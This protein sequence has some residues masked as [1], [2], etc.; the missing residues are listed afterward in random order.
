VS[1]PT[2]GA[3]AYDGYYFG[4]FTTKNRVEL[5]KAAG[6]YTVLKTAPLPLTPERA[7]QVRIEAR[8][9]QIRV[10]VDNM[11]L[12]IIE[13]SDASFTEGSIGVRQYGGIAEKAQATFAR[14]KVTAL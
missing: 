4:L 10:F 11:V 3:D 5:G 7:Y 14:I 1:K 8:G 6:K 12:P 9:S 13:A 2:I